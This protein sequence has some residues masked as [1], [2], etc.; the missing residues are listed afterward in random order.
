MKASAS[1]PQSK[2]IRPLK[3]IVKQMVPVEKW[4]DLIEQ[5]KKKHGKPPVI[6]LDYLRK[7]KSEKSN[8]EERLRVDGL[9]SNLT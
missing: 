1:F 5:I 8:G 9:L 4:H 7:L 3:Y 2:T 6:I